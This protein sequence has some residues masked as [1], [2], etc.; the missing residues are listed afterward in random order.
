MC[1]GCYEEYGEPQIDTPQVREAAARINAVFDE[2][3]T[4]GNWHVVIDDWNL[5]DDCVGSCME[6]ADL[7]TAEKALGEVLPMLSLD[8]RASALALADGYWGDT[9]QLSQGEG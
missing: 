9:N 8:E 6:A 5:E 4:G 7:T 3:L 2:C 1:Y